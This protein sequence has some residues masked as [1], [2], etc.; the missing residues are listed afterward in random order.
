MRPNCD[1]GLA[2]SA[3]TNDWRSRVDVNDEIV[4]VVLTKAKRESRARSIKH[5][6]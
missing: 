6:G 2:A 5:A 1:A 3:E 4:N